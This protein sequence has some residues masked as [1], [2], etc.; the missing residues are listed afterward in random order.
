[1]AEASRNS[2]ERGHSRG[3]AKGMALGRDEALGLVAAER[4]RLH[5]QAGA[6]LEGFAAEREQYFHLVERETVRLALAIASRVLRRETQMDALLLTGV[7]RVA[8]GQLAE[9]TTVRLRIP[10]ED[11]ALWKEAFRHMPGLRVSPTVVGDR[12]LEPGDCRMETDLGTVDLG[13]AAQLKEIERGFFDRVGV[14]AS[15]SRIDSAC[16]SESGSAGKDSS[17][18]FQQVE[19]LGPPVAFSR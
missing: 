7:V 6:L 5:A 10:I 1:M 11:E 2:E 14:E 15:G 12:R 19:S 16:G 9:S 18:R 8:L 3:L 17:L 13:L 4:V